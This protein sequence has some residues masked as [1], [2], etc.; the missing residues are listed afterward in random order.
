LTLVVDPG[1][2]LVIASFATPIVGIFLYY[3]QARFAR[4]SEVDKEA[5]QK[6]TEKYAA[7]IDEIPF[8]FLAKIRDELSPDEQLAH[9]K[10]FFAQ[11]GHIWLHSISDDTIRRLN[12]VIALYGAAPTQ[13]PAGRT[14]A[15]FIVAARREIHSKTTLTAEDYRFVTV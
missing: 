8:V 3:L 14:V 13:N 15:E 6:V 1:L 4:K 2:A 11:Y 12:D 10:R 9:K 5:R 7:I